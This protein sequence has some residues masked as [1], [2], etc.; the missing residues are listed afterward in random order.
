M[1]V[2]LL[3]SLLFGAVAAADVDEGDEQ[4]EDDVPAV[5]VW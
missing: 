3:F 5:G 1:L 2:G 4:L